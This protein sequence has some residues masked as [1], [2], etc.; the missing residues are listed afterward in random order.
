MPS[1][2]QGKRIAGGIEKHKL[3]SQSPWNHTMKKNVLV[4]VFVNLLKIRTWTFCK[5][6]HF[7]ENYFIF[8]L[9]FSLL[10]SW[11]DT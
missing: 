11:K 7:F 5:N 1:I 9:I 2:I 6:R 4:N 10:F 3:N 8:T